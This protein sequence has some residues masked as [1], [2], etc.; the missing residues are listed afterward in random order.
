[1]SYRRVFEVREIYKPLINRVIEKFYLVEFAAIFES[2]RL[3][4]VQN[5]EFD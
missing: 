3:Q 1:M 2:Q 4:E 5:A